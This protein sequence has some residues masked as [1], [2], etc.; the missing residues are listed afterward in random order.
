[1]FKQIVM[2]MQET[3]IW[4]CLPYDEMDDA[5]NSILSIDKLPNC[6]QISASA[7]TLPMTHGTDLSRGW[8]M[9]RVCQ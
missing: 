7:A 9:H 8:G 6:L 1:M 2:D 4:V 5:G 3:Q